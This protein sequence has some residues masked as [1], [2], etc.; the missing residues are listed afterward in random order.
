MLPRRQQSWPDTSCL[1]VVRPYISHSCG[2]DISRMSWGTVFKFGTNVFFDSRTNSLDFGGE[3]SH[4]LCPQVY[5][6]DPS[7]SCDITEMPLGFFFFQICHICPCGFSD[8]LFRFWWLKVKFTVTHVL[9]LSTLYFRIAWREFH[10]AQMSTW[11][12][13]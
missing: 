6:V 5:P 13:A 10:L 12:C 11:A 8:Q 7:H 9:F 3:R 2:R 4:W 1:W